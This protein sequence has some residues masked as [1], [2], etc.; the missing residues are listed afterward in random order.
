[1]DEP[2]IKKYQLE[3]IEILKENQA[4]IRKKYASIRDAYQI[5]YDWPEFDTL[6]HE[7][8]LALMF[9]LNQAAITLTNHMLESLL[10]NALIVFH[11]HSIDKKSSENP[12]EQM[13]E[14]TAPAQKK[15]GKMNLSRTIDETFKAGLISE[16]EKEKLHAFREFMRNAYGHADKVKTFRDGEVPVQAIELG[17]P[18]EI[19]N[20]QNVK[21]ADLL[22]GQGLIQA[23]LAEREATGYFLEIDSL[24]RN[25]M[26]KIFPQQEEAPE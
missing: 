15:F 26:T 2:T 6:R 20:P 18:P 17:D 3:I 8:S 1:M 19:T 7:I 9:N 12:L 10:K 5:S 11:S 25:L 23:M 24:V 21:I 14:S 16:N 4:T 13:M 22:V